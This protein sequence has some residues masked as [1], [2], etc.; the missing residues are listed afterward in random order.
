MRIRSSNSII[1]ID[2]SSNF[3]IE[4]LFC[5][6]SVVSSRVREKR[7]SGKREEEGE[8]GEGEEKG[9]EKEKRKR[10]RVLH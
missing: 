8:G 6:R 1:S 7:E 10:K 4:S 9:N 3:R 5:P 2:I